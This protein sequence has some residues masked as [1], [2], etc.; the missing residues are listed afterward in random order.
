MKYTKFSSR[1]IRYLKARLK[2]A[3]GYIE[4]GDGELYHMGV[5]KIKNNIAALQRL[6]DDESQW[7]E[8]PKE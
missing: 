6:L 5:L 2:R 4:S 8:Q 1:N 3:I 7:E